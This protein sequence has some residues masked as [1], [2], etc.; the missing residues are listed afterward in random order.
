MFFLVK[1]NYKNRN[2]KF[3]NL[4]KMVKKLVATTGIFD[5]WHYNQKNDI[6]RNDIEQNDIKQNYNQQNSV[7]T[8]T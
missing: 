7:R 2:L 6:E 1:K 8:F 3:K 4:G 5:R